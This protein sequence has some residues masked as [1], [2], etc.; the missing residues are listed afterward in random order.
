M[1]LINEP[2]NV[3]KDVIST[4]ES[5]GFEI[6]YLP[7]YSPDFNPIELSFS[8]LKKV[9]RRQQDVRGD[10]SPEEFARLV[11]EATKVAVTPQM[12]RNEFRHCHIRVD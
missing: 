9:L 5:C 6:Q 8:V 4:I 10:E 1:C 11:L 7:P 2:L 12:A 3:F